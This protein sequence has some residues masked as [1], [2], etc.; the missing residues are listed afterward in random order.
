[1]SGENFW[2]VD[3]VKMYNFQSNRKLIFVSPV[4]TLWT[5]FEDWF[6]LIIWEFIL[7]FYFYLQSTLKIWILLTNFG[8]PKQVSC[9]K[10]MLF[11]DSNFSCEQE[12]FL[13]RYL[14]LHRS[15]WSAIQ[16]CTLNGGWSYYRGKMAFPAS[17]G[18]KVAQ[19]QYGT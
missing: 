19:R 13:K 14:G 17:I 16:D 2:P 6:K 9:R 5:V 10:F 15:R 11:E 3:P 4:F 7:L 1:M 12:H 8:K 18:G